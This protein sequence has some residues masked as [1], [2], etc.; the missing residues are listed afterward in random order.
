[1]QYSVN[2]QNARCNDK[3]NLYFYIYVE[4][5][6]NR[7]YQIRVKCDHTVVFIKWW[8]V[9]ITARGN[10]F[11]AYCGKPE[12]NFRHRGVRLL[13]TECVKFVS[14]TYYYVLVQVRV[15]SVPMF[16]NLHVR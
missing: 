8:A 3:D 7:I 13:H 12:V 2:L 15:K 9:D 14:L 5:F 4:I 1:V 11:P 10:K 16:V 6:Q